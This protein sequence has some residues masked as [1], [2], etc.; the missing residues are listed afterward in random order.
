MNRSRITFIISLLLALAFVYAAGVKLWGYMHSK[1]GFDF[2][3]FMKNYH[4]LLFWGLMVAQL[5]IAGLLLFRRLRLAGLYGAFFML[6]GL[7][8]YLYVMLHYANHIPCA[9]TG[10][11]QGLS[12]QG[13][14]WFTIGF[15]VLAGAGVTLLPKDIHAR[16]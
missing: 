5:A 9:C 11:I 2:F 15:T 4:Q 8:T 16:G 1:T 6:A 10:I 7:S 12:W 13:H 14:L 3:P